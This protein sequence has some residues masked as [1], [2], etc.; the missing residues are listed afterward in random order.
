MKNV[1]I[2]DGS[3]NCTF[4]VFQFSDE[5]FTQIFAGHGQDI[6]FADEIHDRL[7]LADAAKAFEGVW[8]RPVDKQK[9]VGLHG[10]IFYGFE[11]RRECFPA[12]RRE[13]DW[14]DSTVNFAQRTLNTLK[15]SFLET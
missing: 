8:D 3:T 6:A 2:I 4:S 14:D 5:Q 10:T 11:D 7:S 12:T 13:C 9:M 1:Q 15:R